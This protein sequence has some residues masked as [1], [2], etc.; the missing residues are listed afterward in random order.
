[1]SISLAI[2]AHSTLNPN[3]IGTGAKDAGMLHVSALPALATGRLHCLVAAA[4]GGARVRGSLALPT[5]K[6]LRGKLGFLA[7]EGVLAQL[8]IVIVL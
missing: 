7:L 6:I 1:V 3:A 4:F 5:N 2:H 8:A